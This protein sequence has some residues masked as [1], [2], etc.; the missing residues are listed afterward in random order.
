M[1]STGGAAISPS[2]GAAISSTGGAAISP[3]VSAVAAHGVLG[4]IGEY[5]GDAGRILGEAHLAADDIANPDASLDLRGYCAMFEQAARQTGVDDFGL[6]FGRAYQL[7][8]MGPLGELVVNSPT[9]GTALAHLCKYFAAVQEHSDLT[10]ATDGDLLRLE[11]QIRDGR[12]AAR[13]QDAELSIA[14]F[15]NIFRRCI[16]G[17]SPAEIHFEHLRAA[18]PLAHASLLNAP[19]YFAQPRNAILFAK[20]ILTRPMPGA[21]PSKLPALAASLRVR[22]GQARADDFIGLVV[23]QIRA[24]LPAGDASLTGIATRLGMSEAKLYRQL[25]ALGTDLSSLTQ[26]IRHELGLAY[27]AQPHVPLTDIAALLG[28]SE[29]SAFSRA[30]KRWTGMAPA[31]YRA[32]YRSRINQL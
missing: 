32:T 25:A 26:T 3:T 16:P 11:Y 6:R 5:G 13:R 22:A 10:L 31:S 28:Y 7:E 15:N 30:F 14:I 9:L 12:I 29:L 21:D 27:T 19:V 20:D 2:G 17:W 18:E 24:N 23:A 4:L 8:R 1:S